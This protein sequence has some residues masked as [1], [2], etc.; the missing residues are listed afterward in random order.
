[1]NFSS[2]HMFAILLLLAMGF[3][4]CAG[5]SAPESGTLVPGSTSRTEVIPAPEGTTV[6]VHATNVSQSSTCSPITITQTDGSQVTLSCKPQRIVLAGANQAEMIIA[7]GAQNQVVGV[8]H[9]ITNVSYVMDKLPQ[10][11]DVGDWQIPNV[12]RILALHPDVV[13]A[14]ASSKPKNLDQFTSANITVIYLD[15]FRLSTLAS[16][17]R[18]MGK[19]TGKS[20]EAEV[21]ARMVEDTVADVTGRVKKISPENYPSVYSE[22]YSDY[23]V[24][25]PSSGAGEM[26]TLAGGTNIA[27]NV[28]LSSAKI[29]SEWVIARQP[30]FVFKVLPSSNTLTLPETL[31]LLKDRQGWYNIP[32]VKNDRVYLISNDVQ[33]SPRAYIGLVYTAQTLHP[34]EFRDMHP[35]AML[36]EY[37]SRYVSGT[38]KTGM[39]YP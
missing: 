37:A 23:T 12:E 26:L 34:D 8:V 27:D 13:I 1:M 20:N 31:K 19:L 25:G 14:Y 38:N 39:V 15:C 17:A 3:V 36:D 5:C 30:D 24:A 21:Y 29:N 10:A 33:M 18:A 35:W 7:L 28:T 22:S 2:S 32:A 16:D 4:L 11:E 9:S 6:A